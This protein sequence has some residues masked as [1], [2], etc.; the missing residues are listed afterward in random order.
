MQEYLATS[1]KEMASLIRMVASNRVAGSMREPCILRYGSLSFT[2]Q[3][4]DGIAGL[5]PAKHFA[6]M[7]K[8][9]DKMPAPKPKKPAAEKLVITEPEDLFGF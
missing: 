5:G 9:W 6:T 3:T 2:F 8:E 7:A 1:P 4:S